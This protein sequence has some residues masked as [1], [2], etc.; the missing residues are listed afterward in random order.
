MSGQDLCGDA[1]AIRPAHPAPDR[2]A[3]GALAPGRAGAARLDWAALTNR[4]PG[5][6]PPPDPNSRAAAARSC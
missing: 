5:R 4:A 6:P 2:Y 1:W 3:A